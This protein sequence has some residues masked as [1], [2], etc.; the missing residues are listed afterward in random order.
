VTLASFKINHYVGLVVF[1]M[2]TIDLL[3]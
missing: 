1:L 2:T 3:K